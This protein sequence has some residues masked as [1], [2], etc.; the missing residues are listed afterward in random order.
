MILARLLT[1]ADFGIAATFSMIIALL[2]F[3]AKMGVA[4]FLVRD[5]EGNDPEF[6]AAAH[7]VQFTVGSASA[8]LIIVAAWPLARLFG[9]SQHVWAIVA[10][11]LIPLFRGCEHMDVRRFERELRFVPSSLV[12]VIPQVLITLAAW[13]VAKWLGDYRAL[14]VLLLAKALFSCAASHWLAERRYGWQVQRDYIS[15]MIR[16]GWPLLMNGFLSFGIMQG[17]Q[18]L[19]ATFYTMADLAPYAAAA[20]LALAPGFF[21][22]RVFNSVLLPLLAKAQDDPQKFRQRYNQVVSGL[23]C[24][25]ASCSVGLILGGEDFMRL[26]YGQKYVGSGLVLS[27]LAAVSGLRLVRV[28]TAVAALAKGDSQNEMWSNGARLLGLLPALVLAALQQPV[29]WIACTGLLGEAVACWVAIVRLRR[30]DGVSLAAP[31]IPLAWVTA[32][33]ATAGL[34]VGLG[35]HGWPLPWSLLSVGLAAGAAGSLMVWVLPELRREVLALRHG[36]RIAGWR[37][38]L[39]LLKGYGLAQKQAAP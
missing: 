2:E 5:K 1:K 20:A 33:I 35:V 36:V 37:G 14:L 24:V 7:L 39:P 22:G 32:L 31:V 11:A 26:V 18:F 28:A 34:A 16:F 38:L 4:R 9:I 10:I 27:S 12:D 29:W 21:F 6:V 23:A 17:E 19:V 13:P 25:S 8:L 30:R 15:R 3:S